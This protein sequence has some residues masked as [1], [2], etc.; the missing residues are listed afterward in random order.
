[1][2]STRTLGSHNTG[3]Y[4]DHPR[5]TEETPCI[6][7]WTLAD[8]DEG[9][10]LLTV[11]N[12][13][14][15]ELRA[16]YDSMQLAVGRKAW[17]SADIL[18]WHAWLTRQY[19]QLLDTG[20]TC[21]DLLN[22]AQERLVWREV[23]E[24]SGETGA[25]LRPAA[26]A[27]SAQ[28]AHRL[29]SDWQLDEHPLEALGGGETRTF[30][31][32]R[33][34]F[35]AELAQRQLL[36]TA[37]L[38]SLIAEAYANDALT[39]PRS[40]VH[41][42]FDALSPAQHGLFERLQHKG[43][44]V[45]AHDN[46]GAAA[47][48][49]RVE[50]TDADDEIR[51]A[52]TWAR[53]QLATREQPRI[54]IVSTQLAQQRRDLERVFTEILTPA[55]YLAPDSV[56][57]C[58]NISLGEPLSDRPLVAHALLALDLLCGEQPLNLVGQLLRSPFIGSHQAEWEGRALLDAMLRREGMPRIDLHRLRHRLNHLDRDDPRHCPDL[59][60]R[61][62]ALTQRR[63]KLPGT[64]SPSHWAQHLRQLLNL[65]GWPGE[66]TLNS[67][68]FQQVERLHR[69]FSE[70]ATLGKVRPRMRLGEAVSQL[71]ALARDTVFQAQSAV[72]PVQVL[73]PLEAAGM[74]FDA[75]WLL[76]MHDQNW[77]PAPRPDPLLPTQL[78]RDL[79]M[80]HASAARELEFAHTLLDRLLHDTRMII[81]SHALSDG[82]RVLRISPLVRDWPSVPRSAIA[83]P[84][85]AGLHAA[86]TAVDRREALPP[87]QASR[88]PAEVRGGASL[89]GAQ[90]NC[91]FRA[92]AQYRL[93]AM[94]LDEPSHA[95]DGALL[96]RLIHELLQR[97]WQ[98]LHASHSLAALDESGL[99][100]LV[101]P[102]AAATLEDIGRRRPDLFTPRFR[103]IEAL[104]LTRLVI[105]WL[106]VERARAQGFE[107][108]ALEQDQVFEIAGLRL[109]MRIDRVDRLDDGSL[110]I[111]DYKTG[112]KV[113]NAG[114]FDER[115][116][117]P[118]LPLYC[119]QGG[120]DVSAVL[121]ARVRRDDK[122]CGFVGLSREPGAAPGLTTPE[123]AEDG[124]DWTTLLTRWQHALN[125]LA[126]E[127]AD[128]RADPTPSPQAC[129][130]C[131]L[132]ALCR[133]RDMLLE[134]N[135]D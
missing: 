84:D 130:F 51:L 59:A 115:L 19:Q 68:E 81:A 30:L 60:A 89:L 76:G 116:T 72:T 14:A 120:N 61:L 110:A 52:A 49:I 29:C 57:N 131:P 74:A 47:E 80:P 111:I 73:G 105:D 70:L 100:A 24:R 93:G 5:P 11:N 91:P 66:Q 12:R 95:A 9:T 28:T 40:L 23:I 124:T 67:D 133:V 38:T 102:L 45:C 62:E 108:V 17:P 128:G 71:R 126:C 32:W 53:E 134:D 123:Q 113:S 125:S 121:L 117:E 50:A 85:P 107:V 87:A 63:D 135:G 43:C 94:P 96:G 88:A 33:R 109:S 13:L 35:E 4:T 132:G 98:V 42:G 106:N 114:W 27:E 119:V 26:A 34:A 25:L 1:M 37:G 3:R 64:D 2:G 16:R 69:L 8:L 129:E 92:V 122:G 18:P 46:C 6:V 127:I 112:R 7:T 103:S 90:A 101:A 82:D 15:T 118:Q 44:K 99:Q 65:L 48:Q 31:K 41:S 79:G 86:C 77:P 22:P 36:S 54:A 10:T 56:Q 21:L 75:V 58:F 39:P 55:A 104:R 78:Q 97:V 83:P 20:H